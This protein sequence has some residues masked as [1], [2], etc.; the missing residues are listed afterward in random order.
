MLL[1]N[2]R[3]VRG[4]GLGKGTSFVQNQLLVSATELCGLSLSIVFFY[5]CCPALKSQNMF[6]D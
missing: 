4:L 1:T 2:K 3:G 6:H 5:F